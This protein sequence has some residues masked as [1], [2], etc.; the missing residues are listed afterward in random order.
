[1]INI[2]K[3]A[4]TLY[5]IECAFNEYT[6]GYMVV[7]FC[8]LSAEKKQYYI[9]KVSF[10]LDNIDEAIDVVHARWA[11]SMA[12]KG[13]TGPLLVPFD[14]LPTIE[15]IKIGFEGI[16]VMFAYELDSKGVSNNA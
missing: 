2:N 5:K 4:E 16:T 10:N 7:P 15:Q 9:D 3:L 14:K 11:T 12:R 1:M 13:H 6:G 8:N